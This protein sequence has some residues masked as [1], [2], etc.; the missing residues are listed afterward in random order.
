MTAKVRSI[1]NQIFNSSLQIIKSNYSSL[2]SS[3]L[4]LPSNVKYSVADKGS[5][6]IIMSHDNYINEGLKQLSTSFYERINYSKHKHNLAAINRLVDFLFKRKYI[7]LNEKRFLLSEK[8]CSHRNFYLLPK[9]HKNQ[10]SI[11][12]VQPK[13]RPIV[14]C[15]YTETYKIAIFIDYFLQPIVQKSRSFI[16]DSFNFIAI[17]H[18]FIVSDV[19]F[20]VTIDI[21]SLYTNI[22]IEGAITAITTMFNRYKDNRRPDSV[23]INLLKI[24]LY[25]NDFTFN[26]V[27]YIQKKGV[28]MGQR[29]A[30]SVAN[31]YLTLWE[32]TL[33]SQSSIT[34]IVWHRYIDDIFCVW[35]GNEQD[36]HSFLS[37]TNTHDPNITI[38]YDINKQSCIFLDLNIYKEDTH[39]HHKIHFKDTNNHI[40]LDLTS[41]HPKHVFKGIVYSQ[42]R[43]WAAL[44]ST[45]DNFNSTCNNI[46]PIW[47]SKGY[48][49]TLIRN[50]KKQVLKD[51]NLFSNWEHIFSPCGNC[52][53][54][55]Y[56]IK[57]KTFIINDVKYKIIGNYSCM[58]KNVIYLI[59]C[60]SC[61][62]FYVGQTED[63]HTRLSKHINLISNKCNMI[64]HK[65]F[66][67]SCSLNNLKC[68]II[69]AAKNSTK[70]KVKESNYIKKFKTKHPGGLNTIQ[71]YSGTPSLILP[72][73]KLSYKISSN[74]INIC[75]NNNV[76]IKSI[77][78]Q[79]KSLQNMLK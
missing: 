37:F 72:F 78:K 28:A 73:N 62:L 16:K 22:P 51:L 48:T 66:W 53:L 12:N 69:D 24:I 18:D 10:W 29:F 43:R 57:C 36:L 59:F 30:P 61:N 11:P 42:I 65:H 5:N 67:A 13:G 33:F 34:P 6:W 40:L 19:D 50:S 46:F 56:L 20:L 41:N 21:N 39:L 79:G 38:T 26:N 32:E 45:Q 75:K 2:S 8:T 52:P 35:R 44:T 31:I 23:I 71:N 1:S 64:V 74:I 54:Q 55:N 15:K 77:Y 68:F 63:F 25:N 14:N 49:K 17:L 76:E 60:N 9:I 58:S 27:N 4:T 47:R 70:L 7:S 3:T